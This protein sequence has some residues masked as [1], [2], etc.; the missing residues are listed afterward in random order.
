M[1]YVYVIGLLLS[2]G[3]MAR[4]QAW[5]DF[6][7]PG[8]LKPFHGMRY[9][10]ETQGSFSNN[11]TPLWLNANKYGLSSLESNNGYVRG[12]VARDLA[13]DSIRTVGHRLRR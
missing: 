4:A 12:M 3:L 7:N 10:V 2:A 11:K 8:K 9:M 1:R 6:D 5:T 13:Q